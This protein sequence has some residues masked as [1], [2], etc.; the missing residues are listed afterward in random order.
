MPTSRTKILPSCFCPYCGVTLFETSSGKLI[1]EIKFNVFDFYCW[2]NKNKKYFKSHKPKKG[3]EIK[4]YKKLLAKSPRDALID[5]ILRSDPLCHIFSLSFLDYYSESILSYFIK[6]LYKERNSYIENVYIIQFSR[7]K[8]IRC[9]R[10]KILV[11]PEKDFYISLSPSHTWLDKFANYFYTELIENGIKTLHK[12][13][14]GRFFELIENAVFRFLPGHS[15]RVWWIVDDLIRTPQQNLN[16]NLLRSSF[17][18]KGYLH[19]NTYKYEDNYN[20]FCGYTA[21]ER[22]CTNCGKRLSR[23]YENPLTRLP[24]DFYEF[25][26]KELSKNFE[27]FDINRFEIDI[28][29]KFT[30]YIREKL[31]NDFSKFAV[32]ILNKWTFIDNVVAYVVYLNYKAKSILSG[33]IENL[34]NPNPKYIAGVYKYTDPFLRI[35]AKARDF[36]NTEHYNNPSVYKKLT[37]RDFWKLV[38]QIGLS[39]AS[40]ETQ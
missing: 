7:P 17:L 1:S 5:E 32:G 37:Y 40:A 22:F 39:E 24:I 8:R 38:E 31:P 33:N 20:D 3:S 15:D 30:N 4:K 18:N 12:L 26:K 19:S 13:T 35:V 25:F 36:V 2:V 9:D 16:A 23:I 28:N 29:I 34:F 27:K 14:L 6:E 11:E 10:I 21:T